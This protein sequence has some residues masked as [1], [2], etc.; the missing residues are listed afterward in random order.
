MDGHSLEEHKEKRKK[1]YGTKLVL[2]VR[3]TGSVV[4]EWPSTPGLFT[5][6]F[7]SD[8][9]GGWIRLNGAVCV[10]GPSVL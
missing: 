3:Q 8:E 10:I 4:F 1:Y 7:C 6:W 5:L 9:Q 2:I